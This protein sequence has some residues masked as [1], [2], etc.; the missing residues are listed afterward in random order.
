MIESDRIRKSVLGAP[1][2]AG[3]ERSAMVRHL[4]GRLA[5][6]RDDE[7]ECPDRSR[8]LERFGPEVIGAT[9]LL[10][11][12]LASRDELRERIETS[13]PVVIVEVPHA[14]WIEPM[15][16]AIGA[17]FGSDP[18]RSE[19]KRNDTFRSRRGPIVVAPGTRGRQ[20]DSDNTSRIARAL[21][22]HRTLI[23]VTAGPS[24]S[25]PSD[26]LRACEE[27]LVVGSFDPDAVELLVKHVVGSAPSRR[28]EEDAAAAIEPADLR[29]AIHPARG[30]EGAL[31]RLAAVLEDRLRR[32]RPAD[33]PRLQDLAGYGAALEW[34]LA[35]AADLSAYARNTLSWSACE[36]AVLL[37][38]QPGT[39]KSSF[40]A[41]LAREAGVPLVVGSLA[42]WQADGDGHLGTTLKAMRDFFEVA[43]KAAPCIALID[44]LDSF[45]DRRKFADRDRRY[46]TLV[47]NGLLECLDGAGGRAGVL[48]VGTTN[49]RDRID[50]AILRS[51]RFDRCI[52]IPLPS[53]RD[54][55]AIL[56][57]HLG[58][59]LADA[60]LIA[61]AKR[62]LGGTGADC[63]AWVRRARGRARRAERAL[64]PADLLAE[65][66]ATDA[67]P[68]RADDL[69]AAVHESGH[70]VVAHA[71]GFEVHS[72]ALHR[73]SERGGLTGLRA[74]D[75]YPT[76]E[77]L[78][79]L[80]AVY[81][82]GRAAE[83]LVFGDPSN[84]S[85]SDLA[86]ATA[87][88]GRMHCSWGLEGQIAAHPLE[89]A[90][91]EVA[92][93]IERDLRRASD[94]AASILLERRTSFDRLADVLV[95]Q[96][97]LDRA[98]IEATLGIVPECRSASNAS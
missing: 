74:R 10:G 26:L 35:A 57:H 2:P 13:A 82:A 25:L 59:D 96:R 89:L 46:W 50:P 91:N 3:G 5:E 67:S 23:G 24:A 37:V 80:L 44:E 61:P 86:V 64:S 52:T 54:L 63:A 75:M 73:T 29:I 90:S 79:D 30:A 98:E 20:Y 60:D 48:L 53:I 15:A 71:L 12:C 85:A 62:A 68:S 45:G 7:A 32:S 72:I 39:G 87:I 41:A 93:A 84:G 83:I 55:A 6:R 14:D 81:L 22:D 66:D 76:A 27:R 33:A 16:S 40:A 9:I 47:V 77:G 92:A 94:V 65:I 36:N 95:A 56:R 17:V 69:R 34:G 97:A 21:R 58:R 49:D 78:R 42:R 51:G 38:G 19:E 11:Y 4:L 70:A 31:D 28:I 43:R 18:Q 8:I 1:Q 88:C